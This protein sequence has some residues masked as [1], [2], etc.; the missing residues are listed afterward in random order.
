MRGRG[1]VSA[2]PFLDPRV[3]E[4]CFD[5]GPLI[6]AHEADPLLLP[7]M[8]WFKGR[9]HLLK[10]VVGEVQGLAGST[11]AIPGWCAQHE[12]ILGEDLARYAE[13]RRRWG[14]QPDRDRGEAVS[15]V[16]A[17]RNGWR[18]VID[19][20]IGLQTAIDEGIVAT[21]TR[22]LLVSTVRAGWWDANAAWD[23]YVRL[24]EYHRKTGSYP[25]LGPQLWTRADDFRALCVVTSFD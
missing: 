23:A 25:R 11:I 7:L 6:R 18:L 2:T 21:R 4:W 9:A 22:N 16:A 14:S 24:L 17:R 12:L 20:R 10:E 8:Q 3:G 5:A 19:E 15:I 1:S 13:L